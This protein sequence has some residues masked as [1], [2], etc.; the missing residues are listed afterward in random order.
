MSIDG[1]RGI[2]NL[3]DVIP[4]QSIEENVIAFTDW[5]FLK[6]GSYVNV[7]YPTSGNYGGNQHRLK[8]VN[9]PRYTNGR[10]WE[11]AHTNWVW[12]SGT[13]YSP[14][15]IQISGIFINNVFRPIN[16]GYYI[17]YPNGRVIFDSPMPARSGVHLEYSYKYINVLPGDEFPDLLK[18][19]TK[20]A[21]IDGTSYSSNSGVYSLLSDQRVELPAIVIDSAKK[22]TYKGY[23]LGGGLTY[24]VRVVAHVISED[25][26]MT[27]KLAGIIGGGLKDKTLLM[28][29]PQLVQTQ[30]GYPLDYRGAKTNN[31]KTYPQM[32]AYSGDGGYRTNRNIMNSKLF[33]KDTEEQGCY[34]ISNNVYHHPVTLTIE[35]IL[36]Q[37]QT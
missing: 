30:D 17:D 10:V 15:P 23:Q 16:N 5:A 29:D 35:V 8:P 25:E 9:D 26:S 19:V 1:F 14:D 32:I 22:G 6:I 7:N 28:Y 37:S 20:S 12:E 11:G 3:S 36:P 31:A 33:I 4:S 21:R 34:P 13:T 27:N 18:A 2:H 24:T